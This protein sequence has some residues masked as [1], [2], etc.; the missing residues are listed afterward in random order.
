MAIDSKSNGTIEVWF[1]FVYVSVGW[2]S[3]NPLGFSLRGEVVELQKI[4]PGLTSVYVPFV[5]LF[6][7]DFSMPIKEFTMNVCGKRK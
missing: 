2:I 5:S 3:H 6:P 1:Y 4:F 7:L